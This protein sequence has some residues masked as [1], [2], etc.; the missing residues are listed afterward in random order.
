[1]VLCKDPC[2]PS[3]FLHNPAVP[4]VFR[5]W[6]L[7]FVPAERKTKPK[8]VPCGGCSGFWGSGLLSEGLGLVFR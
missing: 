2:C 3:C 6:G 7:G 5:V 4:R 8:T 1:M